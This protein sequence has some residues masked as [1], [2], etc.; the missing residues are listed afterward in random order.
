MGWGGLRVWGGCPC[1]LYACRL[2]TLP[3]RRLVLLSP[4]PPPPLPST[5]TQNLIILLQLSERTRVLAPGFARMLLKQYA[6][7]AVPVTLWVTAFATNLGLA[8]R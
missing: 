3:S 1:R 2:V 6:Y 8:L 5:H 7:A 4:A